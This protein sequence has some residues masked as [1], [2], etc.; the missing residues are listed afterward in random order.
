M[1]APTAA[2]YPPSRALAVDDLLMRPGAANRQRLRQSVPPILSGQQERFHRMTSPRA[3]RVT[4]LRPGL[5]ATRLVIVHDLD[6]LRGPSFQRKH[7]R[8]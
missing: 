3:T 8:H 2:R 6:I 7:T 4:I 1:S 5:P